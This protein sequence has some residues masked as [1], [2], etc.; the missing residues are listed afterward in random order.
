MGA[1]RALNVHALVGSG[2]AAMAERLA[3]NGLANDT[4]KI[5]VAD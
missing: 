5:F 1:C 4:K 3:S 2:S